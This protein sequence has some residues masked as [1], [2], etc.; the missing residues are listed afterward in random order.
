MPHRTAVTPSATLPVGRRPVL[1][2]SLVLIALI[3]AAAGWDIVDGYRAYRRLAERQ[4]ATL[5]GAA[6]SQVEASV[7][8]IDLLLEDAAKS[9]DLDRWPDAETE[10]WLRARLAS[11]PEVRNLI[12]VDASGHTVGPNLSNWAAQATA[13]D[14]SDREYFR[15]LRDNWGKHDVYIS[16]PVIS[17][18]HNQP[19]LPVAHALRPRNGTFGGVV[20]VGLD[21]A[22]FEDMLRG[23][24]AE[25]NLA[26]TLLRRDGVILARY[27]DGARYRGRSVADGSVLREHVP[28]APSGVVEVI[29][30]LDGD[31]RL[32]GY[33]SLNGY[34][35]VML[36]VTPLEAALA[37]WRR[38]ALHA[39]ATMVVLSAAVMVLAFLLE[40]RER[41]RRLAVAAAE[42][43]SRVKSELL[44][45]VSHELRTPLN[46][47]IG[48]SDLMLSG[49]GGE[50]LPP[51]SHGYIADIHT[52]GTHLLDLINEILDVAAIEAGKLVL[53]EERVD[54]AELLETCI[55]LIRPSADRHGIVVIG[56][57]LPLPPLRADRR[58]LKEVVLNLLSNSVKFTPDGG[59]VTLSARLDPALGFVIAVADTGVGMNAE[60]LA[61]ALQPFGQVDSRLQRNADGTG[62]G[63]PLCRG[64]IE[65]HGGDLVID[66]HPGHGTTVAVHL[67]ASR[68]IVDAAAVCDATA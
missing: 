14:L 28:R 6:S 35:L 29:S 19:S 67:P 64:L 4:M 50:V 47:I 54:L 30:P 3:A 53:R 9:I 24:A 16:S 38:R 68:A 57:V 15:F 61:T 37:E 60:Q 48:F 10:A 5:A 25:D 20:V 31:K 27:P 45:N 63:L 51:R 41:Q 49:T 17:R 13:A 62:L 44:A 42:R 32:I 39:V 11:F 40:R 23:V 65:L 12:V 26:A 21:P 1:W 55:R 46:A 52:S 33:R 8:A 43:A 34:P 58:R 2:G 56:A 18:L 59:R 36:M 7:R 66:S 22:Y